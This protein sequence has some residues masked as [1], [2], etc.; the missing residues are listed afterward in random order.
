MFVSSPNHA[1]IDPQL[2][3]RST[4]LD[5]ESSP[6]RNL[7]PGSRKL[8]QCRPKTHFGPDLR[9]GGVSYGD[10]SLFCAANGFSTSW[11]LPN[12]PH[13]FLTPPKHYQTIHI[14]LPSLLARFII[15]T[16]HFNIRF[17]SKI[18]GF[19]HGEHLMP[20]QS[21][22][23]CFGYK[24]LHTWSFSSIPSPTSS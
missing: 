20:G 3:P 8:R 10:T 22:P 6:S 15:F 16:S 19:R 23:T 18:I 5:L 12:T 4:K 24:R 9:R 21:S 7:R 14:C 2:A 1:L 13:T 11:L 17:L